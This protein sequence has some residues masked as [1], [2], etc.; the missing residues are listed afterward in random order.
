MEFE[1]KKLEKS[2]VEIMV[3]LTDEDFAKYRDHAIKEI[4]EEIDVKGFRKG[5]IPAHIVEQKV[6]ETTIKAHAQEKAIQKTYAEII[7]K[8]KLEVISHPRISIESSEPLKYKAI[9]AVMPEISIDGYEK[10][11][12]KVK[13]AKLTEKEEKEAIESIEKRNTKYTDTDQAAKMGDRA[14]L[15]FEGFDEDGKSVENTK[16][17]NH[18]V[19]LGENTLIPGFEEE[20]V[21]LKKGEKKEFEIKF[22]SDYFKKDF[23]NKKMKFKIEVKKLE[24]AEIPKLDEEMIEKLIGKKQSIEEF[25]KELQESLQQNKESENQATAENEYVEQLIKLIKV[26]L[27]EIFIDD[28]INHMIEEMKQKINPSAKTDEFLEQIGKTFEE[29]K[30]KY[31]KEAKNRV[32]ARL[33]LREAINATET[34]VS[35]DEIKAELE[36]IKSFY[37]E[38]QHKK[39]EED[40]KKG[41]L[42][43]HIASRLT[44]RKFFDKVI[45]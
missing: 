23:Q 11:S 33:A 6:G 36:K 35:D 43:S 24:K 1:I 5:N 16:S 31:K 22:P 41:S 38:A 42:K 9:V 12:V 27:P 2:E 14:E 8:E 45:K 29:Y 3:T 26:D 44:L 10:I 32:L 21:G 17:S 7:V 4:A 39:I 19:I 15:D 18:P 25:K 20:I 40:Y 28:E 30:E 37:P 34:K 13:E